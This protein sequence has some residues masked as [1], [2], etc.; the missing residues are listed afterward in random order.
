MDA[1]ID[2]YVVRGTVDSDEIDL[3]GACDHFFSLEHAKLLKD[4]AS[5]AEFNLKKEIFGIE[6]DP[7]L[8]TE[9]KDGFNECEIATPKMREY[10]IQ[11]HN[12]LYPMNEEVMTLPLAIDISR[13]FSTEKFS[14]VMIG[15]SHNF[16]RMSAYIKN[17]KSAYSKYT[18]TDN[19]EASWKKQMI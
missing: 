7:L 3:Y 19:Y 8:L 5:V 12:V 13:H 14:P 15:V 10:A 4:C 2:A 16:Y 9:I 17:N 1:Y 18:K 11:I 6:L